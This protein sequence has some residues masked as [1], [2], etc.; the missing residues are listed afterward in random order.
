MLLLLWVEMTME[1]ALKGRTIVRIAQVVWGALLSDNFLSPWPC[2]RWVVTSKEPFIVC[3]F[4]MKQR[5]Y[6]H[7]E[8]RWRG[9]SWILGFRTEGKNLKGAQ[10]GQPSPG[11]KFLC[12]HI[13]LVVSK[14]FHLFSLWTSGFSGHSSLEPHKGQICNAFFF[15]L[16]LFRYSL[17]LSKSRWGRRGGEGL[18]FIYH[19]APCDKG[20]DMSLCEVL[21]HHSKD[22]VVLSPIPGHK[23]DL[24]SIF[25]DFVTI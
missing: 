24:W 11:V 3:M 6:P 15:A 23:V 8:G 10:V 14:P 9:R 17:R 2:T 18:P 20:G 7:E 22:G 12:F 1:L 4:H 19:D 16:V 5:P 21:R 25:I 13:P